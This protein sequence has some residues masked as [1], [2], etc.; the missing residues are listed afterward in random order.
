MFWLVRE[1]ER[2]NLLTRNN[3]LGHVC[4]SSWD[5]NGRVK[6]FGKACKLDCRKKVHGSRY[7][8]GSM[9][10]KT[11]CKLSSVAAIASST[12]SLAHYQ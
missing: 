11:S 3:N 2:D 5:Q 4:E 8:N 1:R 9:S 12:Q 6:A 7:T 10:I